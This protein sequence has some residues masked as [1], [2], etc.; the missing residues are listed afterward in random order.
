MILTLVDFV[1]RDLTETKE[2]KDNKSRLYF[3][4]L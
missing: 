4:V 3:D 2:W 1:F